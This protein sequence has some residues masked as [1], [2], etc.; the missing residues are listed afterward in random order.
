[1][2]EDRV[3]TDCYIQTLSDAGSGDTATETS[4]KLS[5]QSRVATEAP[6]YVGKF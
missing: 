2:Y 3:E 1:M 6:S 5:E 4:S